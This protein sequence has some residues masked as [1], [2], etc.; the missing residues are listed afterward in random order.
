VNSTVEGKMA[1][2]YFN[3]GERVKISEKALED[4]PTKYSELF[5]KSKSAGMEGEYMGDILVGEVI[6]SIIEFDNG[7]TEFIRKNY[8]EDI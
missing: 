5:I 6:L 1:E 2:Q 7:K 3:I 8:L 4:A